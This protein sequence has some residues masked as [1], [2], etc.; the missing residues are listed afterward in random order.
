MNMAKK[1]DWDERG[2]RMTG[3]TVKHGDTYY[4]AYGSGSPGT[5]IG[6][7]TVAPGSVGAMWIIEDFRIGIA[8][9]SDCQPESF[10]L[11]THLMGAAV[12]HPSNGPCDLYTEGWWSLRLCNPCGDKC[13][14]PT[15][16]SS[17]G[18]IKSHYR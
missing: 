13:P 9:A 16:S 18:L 17:W 2:M 14:I 6:F 7:L 11:C 8:T 1:G 5:K 3:S 15:E 12:V 4:M 10:R